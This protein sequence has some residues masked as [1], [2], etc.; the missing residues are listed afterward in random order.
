MGSKS[1]ASA[2]PRQHQVGVV[3]LAGVPGCYALAGSKHSKQEVSVPEEALRLLAGA[4]R[5]LG[6]YTLLCHFATGGMASLYLARFTG[7]DGF[8][9]RVAIKQIHEHLNTQEEFIK[10][11]VDEARLAARITHPNV[12]Q[13]MELGAAGASHFIAMEYVNGESLAALIRRS[14]PPYPLC[15]RIVADSAAGLHAAHELRGRDDELLGVVHRDVSPQ[16]ILISYEGAVKVVDFGVARARDRLQQATRAGVVKGKYSYM[17]PEQLEGGAIDRRADI[18]A[19]GIVLYEVTTRHRLFKG[20][21]EAETIAKVARGKIVPPSR[22]VFDYPPSLERIV[23]KALQRDPALRHQSA[24]ELQEALESFIIESGVP[25]L[26]STLAAMMQEVFAERIAYKKQMLSFSERLDQALPAVELGSDAS[27]TLDGRADSA[28]L[29]PAGG[30]GTQRRL[31]LFVGLSAAALVLSVAILVAVLV[32]GRQERKAAAAADRAADRSHV[33]SP[34]EKK[35]VRIS[36]LVRPASA[37]IKVDGEPRDNP[38]VVTR[39]AAPGVSKIL[40]SAPGY[41]SQ[42][43][44]VPLAEGGRWV[45]ALERDTPPPQRQPDSRVA[46]KRTSD[47]KTK[48]KVRPTTDDDDDD[49]LLDNPYGE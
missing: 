12:V 36:I 39:E 46:P 8:E 40:V 32:A 9:K 10:M 30:R 31:A 47:G 2:G 7:P 21:S 3:L 26:P 29:L 45:I 15:A 34:P 5:Q 11:F 41:I 33:V 42:H 38:Y 37:T 24:A 35:Q 19:L 48:K 27:L 28:S 18:F 23:L 16:N 43:F 14:K 13:V 25:V 6:R 4:Q 44:S 1:R 17:A 49:E 22:L 20:E